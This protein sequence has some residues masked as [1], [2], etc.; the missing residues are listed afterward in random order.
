MTKHEEQETPTFF[1]SRRGRQIGVHEVDLTGIDIESN[2]ASRTVETRP[3]LV[4]AAKKTKPQ[5]RRDT[6][7]GW[8]KQRK[9]IF[10]GALCTIL[11][12]PV[13]CGEFVAAQYRAGITNA[14]KD[15]VHLVQTTVLPA[16]KKSTITADTMRSIAN[17]VNEI[18]G[19]MCRGGLFD[20]AAGLYPRATA[21]L[22]DCKQSQIH[23]A[24]LASSLYSLEAQT[25]Y[26]EKVDAIMKPVATLITDA[27][28]V[29]GSQQ[30]DWQT[31]LE[32]AKK[33]SPPDSMRAAHSELTSAVEASSTAWSELNSAN[34]SRNATDFQGAEQKLLTSYEAVRAVSEKFSQ[35]VGDT[36]SD[37]LSKYSELK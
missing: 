9:I 23:Y 37:I 13:L 6:H 4:K 35:V 20:N 19:H 30:A 14:K 22:D 10:I 36:Q 31:A 33:L 11:V 27:Y 8:T 7:S 16:Q 28:A 29:I 34:N 2:N 24:A 1:V 18:V 32:A 12:F 3:R 25:R 15:L 21:A 5:P 17:D 26:L